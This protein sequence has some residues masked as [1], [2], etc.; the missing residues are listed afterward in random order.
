MDFEMNNLINIHKR[1]PVAYK[2]PDAKI[3]N[4]YDLLKRALFI[5]M[6]VHLLKSDP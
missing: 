4:S 3:I 5:K 6:T 1:I 2:K